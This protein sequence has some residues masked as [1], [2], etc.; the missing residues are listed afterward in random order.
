M[1]FLGP[2]F[3]FSVLGDS[4][5]LTLGDMFFLYVGRKPFRFMH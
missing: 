5:S 2:P 1:Y 3:P 4:D